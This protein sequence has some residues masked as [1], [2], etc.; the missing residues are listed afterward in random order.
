MFVRRL[1]CALAAFL[2]IAP[3]GLR[4]AVAGSEEARLC[5]IAC[6]HAMKAGAACCPMR[7]AGSGSGSNSPTMSP[8]TPDDFPAAAPVS[9]GQ[10]AILI[11]I[12]P[13]PALE[14]RESAIA[15]GP[16]APCAPATRPLDHVPILLS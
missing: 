1:S 12:Q 9:A 16:A 6:G 3:A 11:A 4:L 8:C 13:I 2:L 15:F 7:E 10:P 14:R 5:A